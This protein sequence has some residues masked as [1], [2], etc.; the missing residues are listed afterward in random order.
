M[1]ARAPRVR[2]RVPRV[3]A[4][5]P[6]ARA[7]P[8]VQIQG[9]AHGGP[10]DR[11]LRRRSVRRVVAALRASH[12]R[13]GRR[14]PP[15]AQ[16]VRTRSGGQRRLALRRAP[17]YSMYL[18]LAGLGSRKLSRRSRHPSRRLAHWPAEGQLLQQW[19]SPLATLHPVASSGC[20]GVSDAVAA[21]TYALARAHRT[22]IVAGLFATLAPP[23]ALPRS[24]ADC[25]HRST[26]WGDREV[27]GQSLVA[28]HMPVAQL[29]WQSAWRG[30]S[31]AAAGHR[32][33]GTPLP[34]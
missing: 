7:P 24:L 6:R 26:G 17:H 23:M 15:R 20:L 21:R 12:R 33:S 28:A 34:S 25:L 14:R 16:K 5:A 10:L 9:V 2:A 4:G 27:A 30:V 3:W 22:R 29:H 19:L 1:R 31:A 32:G 18:A 11:P 8:S 13:W